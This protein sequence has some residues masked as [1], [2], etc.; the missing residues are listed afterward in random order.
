MMAVTF[1]FAGSSVAHAKKPTVGGFLEKNRLRVRVVRLP[2]LDGAWRYEGRIVSSV[3]NAPAEYRV[4]AAKYGFGTSLA[5]QGASP[6][7]VTNGLFEKVRGQ[8]LLVDANRTEAREIAVPSSFKINTLTKLPAGTSND[9]QSINPW[10][11]QA[12]KPANE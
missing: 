11:K 8:T 12:R 9:K 5:I 2:Q 7:E 6:L 3:T 10:A 4:A 1:L